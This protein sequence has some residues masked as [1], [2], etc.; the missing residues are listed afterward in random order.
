LVF[1]LQ[2]WG[3]FP[4]RKINVHGTGAKSEDS[5]VKE[6]EEFGHSISIFSSAKYLN[7]V[8]VGASTGLKLRASL[9]IVG[10]ELLTKHLHSL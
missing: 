3:L 1:V 4:S 9:I 7:K 6:E 10:I 5:K 8:G 2:L